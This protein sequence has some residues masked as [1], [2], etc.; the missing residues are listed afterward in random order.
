M[1]KLSTLLLCAV[2]SA[3]TFCSK[4]HAIETE[5]SKVQDQKESIELLMTKGILDPGFTQSEIAN[6]N[7]Q[8]ERLKDEYEQL[9]NYIGE[10]TSKVS[11]LEK[12]IK[13]T[14]RKEP[15]TAFDDDQFSQTVDKVVVLNRDEVE[16]RLKCGLHLKERL[17]RA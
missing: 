3:Q 4:I 15:L 6:V 5:L 9:V 14:S 7:V 17:V 11:E 12:L 13:V 16:F 8:I 2:L 10:D 1:N